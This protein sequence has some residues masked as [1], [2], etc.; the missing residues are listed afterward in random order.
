MSLAFEAKSAGAL[1]LQALSLSA[2]L[3]TLR[4]YSFVFSIFSPH[5]YQLIQL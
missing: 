2:L 3:T 1:E 5:K 4:E